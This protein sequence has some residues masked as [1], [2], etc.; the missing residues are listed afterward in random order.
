M[1]IIPVVQKLNM[2]MTTITGN[3]IRRMIRKIT[4][5]VGAVTGM[6]TTVRGPGERRRVQ[7]RNALRRFGIRG[8]TAAEGGRLDDEQRDGDEVGQQRPAGQRHHAGGGMPVQACGGHLGGPDPRHR[9]GAE[10]Q[11]GHQTGRE[12]DRTELG[13]VTELQ[14]RRDQRDD[15][16]H[17][18]LPGV[19][20]V[21]VADIA[22]EEAEVQRRRQQHE[23]SENH[24]LEVHIGSVAGLPRRRWQP[25]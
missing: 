13:A 7:R 10:L 20:D 22:D 8:L 24:F 18:Q 4:S 15:E 9:C 12:V 2:V 6:S 1:N 5:V 16:R 21:G 19:V 17:E 25:G 23:E 14:H 11:Q 3:R